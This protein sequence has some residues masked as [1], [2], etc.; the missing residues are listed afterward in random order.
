MKALLKDW[1]PY[2][3]KRYYAFAAFTIISIVLPFIIINGN[4]FLLLSF[5]YFQF[6]LFFI[7]FD[8]QELYLIPILL[9]ILFIGIFFITALGGRIWCGWMCPQ[10]I[11]RII[12]RDLIETKILG[13]RKRIKRTN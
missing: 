12:F 13:I 7:K 5:D 10:T 2:R 11:F 8:M 6:H 9:M 4:H 3:Y 1:I